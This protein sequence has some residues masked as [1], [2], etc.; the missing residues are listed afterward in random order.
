MVHL[1][2]VRSDAARNR[3]LI[4]GAARELVAAAGVDATM[5]D[6]ARR[7]GVAV[8]TL[9]RHFPAKEDLIAAVIEDSITHIAELAECALA[10]VE[11]GCGAGE[12][13]GA[14]FA[15]VVERHGTDRALKAAAGLLENPSA[16]DLATAPPGS[17]TARAV[18]AITALLQRARSVG[19]V[20]ADV[21]L[22]DLVMLL[23]A[24]P[25]GEAPPEMRQRYVEI[26]LAGLG[27]GASR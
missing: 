24:A 12:Q 6:I 14:L 22:A 7:A 18:T 9:Y 1:V 21:T 11:G 16:G 20:R 10:A 23:S 15:A 3:R 2:Q 8:G 25:A 4:L 19:A 13:L 26:V 17:A 5:E 27:G